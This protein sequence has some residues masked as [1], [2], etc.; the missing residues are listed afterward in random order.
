MAEDDSRGGGGLDVA[1][2]LAAIE[3]KLDPRWELKTQE[4][5]DKMLSLLHAKSSAQGQKEPGGAER[6]TAPGVGGDWW[7]LPG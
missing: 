4:I 2:H 6:G 7:N 1:H 5:M 3:Q